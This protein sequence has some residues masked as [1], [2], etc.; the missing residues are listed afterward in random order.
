MSDPVVDVP[1]GVTAI[2]IDIEGTTSATEFV[3]QR[4]FPWARQ[5]LESWIAEHGREPQVAAQLAEVRREVGAVGMSDRYAVEV[6]RS[7]IDQDVK[8]TPL[9]AIQGWMWQEGF[10]S[11]QLESHLFDDV[12][13]ALRAWHEAGLRL[14]IYSSGSVT[15]QQSWFG[16]SPAGDLRSLFTGW[17]DTDNAG[18]KREPGSYERIAA[19]LASPPE[20][21][22]FLSDITAELD[23]ARIARWHTVGV[24]RA[25]EPAW[26]AGIG[27]HP[28]ARRF[29]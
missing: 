15:A 12:A 7:W 2:V 13:P 8:A 26:A 16:H 29:A 18:P 3:H 25:G 11:G 21:L 17:F 27:Q 23:A 6:L 19:L 1:T 4:L 9:K 20:E 22:L 14:A 24:R 5:H 10:E 28:E